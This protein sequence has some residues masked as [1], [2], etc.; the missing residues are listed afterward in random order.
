[1]A[2]PVG[3]ASVG[4]AAKAGAE[5]IGAVP[6]NNGGGGRP[7]GS[8][9]QRGPLRRLAVAWGWSEREEWKEELPS[10]EH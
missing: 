10:T 8:R 3:V 9:N 1:M 5:R 6:G 2:I 4:M 7:K